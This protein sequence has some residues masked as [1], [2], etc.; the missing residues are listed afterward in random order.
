MGKNES[1]CLK[2]QRRGVS[3]KFGKEGGR[4]LRKSQ[5]GREGRK[6]R[7]NATRTHL[8]GRSPAQNGDGRLVL[9]AGEDQIVEE[10]SWEEERGEGRRRKRESASFLPLLETSAH[11]ASLGDLR[12]ERLTE[13]IEYT[14]EFE[15]DEYVQVDQLAGGLE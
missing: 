8:V 7:A 14:K 4:E 6:V 2:I 11:N 1:S 13:A 5:C 12:P 10:K 15:R 3:R 9:V